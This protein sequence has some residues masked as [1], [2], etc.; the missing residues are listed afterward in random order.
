MLYNSD[1]QR[2]VFIDIS[3]GQKGDSRLVSIYN[4]RG[5]FKVLVPF[6]PPT[7]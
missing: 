7:S 1:T 4:S 5:T 2:N 6:L 3:Y